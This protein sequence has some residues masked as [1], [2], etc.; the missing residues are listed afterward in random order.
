MSNEVS[1]VDV[2]TPIVANSASRTA[3]SPSEFT[4]KKEKT[5]WNWQRWLQRSHCFKRIPKLLNL[6]DYN[7]TEPP[8]S[9]GSTLTVIPSSS[10]LCDAGGTNSSW[11]C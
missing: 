1:Q 9:S 6:C 7:H 8:T 4:K 3:P 2:V 10:L 11:D 5:S